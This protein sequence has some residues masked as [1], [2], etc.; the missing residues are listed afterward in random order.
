MIDDDIL[1]LGSVRD[2]VDALH[3]HVFVFAP[4]ADYEQLYI[5]LWGSILQRSTLAR[6]RRVNTGLF[7]MRN[8]HDPY[9]I[10]SLLLRG[11]NNLGP[12]GLWEQGFFAA[13]FATDSTLQLPT[14]RYFYPLFDGL[15]GGIFGYD[16]ASNPCG[17][18]SVHFGGLTE[19]PADSVA[20]LLSPSVL[21]TAARKAYA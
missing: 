3:D 2:A 10:A 11:T 1:I 6:T 8:P 18:A 15:P 19:K 13:L 12:M 9:R 14:Q 20:L 16:Y 21:S 5:S 7:W 4:D 17:F